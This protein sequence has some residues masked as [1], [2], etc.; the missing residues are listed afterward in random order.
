VEPKSPTGNEAKL[1]I[2]VFS[3]AKMLSVANDI[4]ANKNNCAIIFFMMKILLKI[5]IVTW[6]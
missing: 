5:K 4:R 3:Y 1:A 2:R 6:I